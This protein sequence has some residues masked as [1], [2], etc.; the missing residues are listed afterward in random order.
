MSTATNYSCHTEFV[1][2]KITIQLADET[3]LWVRQK[4]VDENTSVSKL[5]SQMLERE[6]R[7]SDGLLSGV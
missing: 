3:V 2:K 7:L 5:L 4:A 6:M 1:A